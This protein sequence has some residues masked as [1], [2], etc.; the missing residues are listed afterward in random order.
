MGG[1]ELAVRREKTRW[2]LLGEF[3]QVT[4]GEDRAELVAYF[5]RYPDTTVKQAAA[6]VGQ[7]YA[8]CMTHIQQMATK[9][10]L[11]RSGRGKYRVNDCGSI[12]GEMEAGDAENDGGS[13]DD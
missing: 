11:I 8:A 10:T 3:D 1:L 6:A 5:T 2:V 12:V 9:G 13:A 7:E 4:M